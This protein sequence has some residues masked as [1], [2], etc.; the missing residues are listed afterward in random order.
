MRLG[1]GELDIVAQKGDILAFI[2]VKQRPA[3]ADGLLAVHSDKQARLI[4][5]A[6]IWL[7]QHPQWGRLQCRF[8][9]IILTPGRWIPHVEHL[10]DVFRIDDA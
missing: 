8:D 6:R 1:R 4:S 10:Q 5:A 7:A 2:E 3:R 9:L